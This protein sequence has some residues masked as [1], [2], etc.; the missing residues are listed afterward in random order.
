[1]NLSEM[2]TIVRRDLHDEDSANY[3]WTDDELT[4][5]INHAVKDFSEALP[6]EEK[7]TIATT[8][9]SREV[10]ISSLTDRIGV[11]AVEYPVDRYPAEYVKFQLWG[12]TLTLLMDAAPDG[13]DCCVY[14]GRLHSMDGSSSTIPARHEDLVAGGAEGYAAAEWAQYAIN[15]VNVGGTGTP[16]ELLNWGDRKLAF[17]RS[18]LKRLGRRGKLRPS[19]LYTPY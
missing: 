13:S 7:A 19:E 8:A 4:R 14:Y 18:E 3:R 5:H 1:M 11:Q 9:D 16:Q 6:V 2:L 15:K 10:D 17:F 12:H